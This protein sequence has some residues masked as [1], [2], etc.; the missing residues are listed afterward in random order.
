MS[1]YYFYYCCYYYYCYSYSHNA[2]F[3]VLLV[4]T[5]EA[6]DTHRHV[7]VAALSGLAR[8]LGDCDARQG[9]VRACTAPWVV[10]AWVVAAWVVV[11]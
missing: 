3:D 7:A 1:F 10:A 9:R 6:G 2:P 8:G 5:G 4:G 11:A